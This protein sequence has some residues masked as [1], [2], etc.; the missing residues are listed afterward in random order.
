[1]PTNLY[2]HQLRIHQT[3]PFTKDETTKSWK[4]KNL[5]HYNIKIT[6]SKKVQKYKQQI[7]ILT[8]PTLINK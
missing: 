4:F 8:C 1:M 5:T 6:Q 7:S 3:P 2:N